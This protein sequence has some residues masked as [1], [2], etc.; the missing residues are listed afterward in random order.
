MAYY[1]P[2]LALSG[3][4]RVSG[5]VKCLP[6]YGWHPTV[7]TAKPA[8][9]FAFDESMHREIEAA[10]ADIH[11]TSSLDPTRLFG[12][13][14]T[15]T[16]PSESVRQALAAATQLLFV[17]DNKAVSYTHLTLPTKRIV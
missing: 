10:G 17:P 2:P 5:F 3:V 16:L 4:Q 14:K 1:F 8:G 13:K 7:I 15:V 12:R 9:Y 6:H 11:M